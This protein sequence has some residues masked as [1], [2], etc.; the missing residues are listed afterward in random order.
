MTE[1]QSSIPWYTTID[2]WRLKVAIF[3]MPVLFFLAALFFASESA[4]FLSHAETTE[5]EV[6]RVYE[7][8]GETFLDGDKV[9]GPVIRYSWADGKPTEASLGM[10]HSD[11]NFPIESK[12]TIHYNPRVKDNVRLPGFFFNWMMPSI[13]LGLAVVTLIP[14]WMLWSRV[15]KARRN[16]S[17]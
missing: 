15:R 1:N 12:Q 9:Y 17:R 10:S 3:A 6:V 16:V 5:G 8:E 11:W 4:W 7:W 14:M 2:A 13:L